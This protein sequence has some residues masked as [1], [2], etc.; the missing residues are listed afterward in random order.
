MSQL[1]FVGDNTSIIYSSGYFAPV[2]VLIG[3]GGTNMFTLVGGC[4][5]SDAAV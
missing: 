4:C 3:D 5:F 2:P 1:I